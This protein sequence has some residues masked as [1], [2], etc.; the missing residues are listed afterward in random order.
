[1]ASEPTNGGPL[2]ATKAACIRTYGNQ[3]T[4][5]VA[6]A[7]LQARGIHSW[8]IADDCGGMMP[9]M[10]GG[11]VKLFV[12]SDDAEEAEDI[13]NP[14]IQAEASRAENKRDIKSDVLVR[15]RPKFVIVAGIWA[16]YGTGLIMNIFVLIASLN[17]TIGGLW[18]LI[19][20]WLS[21]GCGALCTYLLY[22]VI[23][24]YRIHK[25]RAA[26]ESDV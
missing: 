3:E 10:A 1:M 9:I 11:G 8:I 23:K 16:I 13:L 15:D 20:F 26:E 4:A 5:Q 2:N 6:A 22:R 21:I 12:R 19:Y 17:G 24:N 18:G 7:S 14:Q 25:K